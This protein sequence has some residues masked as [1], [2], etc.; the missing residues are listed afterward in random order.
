MREKK[1]LPQQAALLQHIEEQ[2]H[3]RASMNMQARL[4]TRAIATIIEQVYERKDRREQ[5]ICVL[6]GR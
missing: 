5:Y 6:K 2:L 4:D 1:S 3:K